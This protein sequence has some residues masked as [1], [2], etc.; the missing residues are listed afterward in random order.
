MHLH[1]FWAVVPML[2][3][4]LLRPAAAVIANVLPDTLFP[5]G[6]RLMPAF[7]GRA[8]DHRLFLLVRFYSVPGFSCKGSKE[9]DG[10]YAVTKAF[11][12]AGGPAMLRSRE[13]GRRVRQG[14]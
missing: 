14:R 2:M 11:S 10:A 7:G 12:L 3:L 13:R 6:L 5:G 4:C 8:A 9:S 1:Q